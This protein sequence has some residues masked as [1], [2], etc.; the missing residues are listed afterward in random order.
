MPTGCTEQCLYRAA[1]FTPSLP[2]LEHCACRGETEA[3]TAATEEAPK[4]SWPPQARGPHAAV[5]L[6]ASCSFRRGAGLSYAQTSPHLA[7]PLRHSTWQQRPP[8]VGGSQAKG[9]PSTPQYLRGA[10]CA[11][12]V[13][14]GG[15]AGSGRRALPTP[16]APV[17][18]GFPPLP[19]SLSCFQSHQATDFPANLKAESCRAGSIKSQGDGAARQ[20]QQS[21]QSSSLEPAAPQPREPPAARPSGVSP[22]AI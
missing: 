8:R 12:P 10:G 14:V 19:L 5:C 4:P 13:E 16:A 3:Q 1:A 7:A 6:A 17:A 11:R 22:L 18:A 2:Q 21:R 20:P 9:S 15:R